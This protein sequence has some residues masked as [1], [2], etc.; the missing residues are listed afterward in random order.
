MKNLKNKEFLT[1]KETQTYLK[2]HGLNWTEVWIR[3]LI[4]SGT[5]KSQMQ[6][7]SRV[8]VRKDLDEL[9]AERQS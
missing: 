7:N 3:R 4:G 8:V 6:F 1:V 5:I 2:G 9:I